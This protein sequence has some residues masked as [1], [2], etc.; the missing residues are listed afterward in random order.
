MVDRFGMQNGSRLQSLYRACK[1]YLRGSFTQL[2][3]E[4][5]DV[6]YIDTRLS[7]S[8]L[9]HAK[10]GVGMS[11]SQSTCW[12]GERDVEDAVRLRLLEGLLKGLDE[13]VHII[14]ANGMTVYYNRKMADIEGMRPED[15]IGKRIEDVFTFPDAAGSTLL[16]AVRLRL[17]RENVKQTYFN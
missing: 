11:S 5:I 8:T 16:Q 4:W 12:I 10:A 7:T 1:L 9:L 6:L 13:G 14:D 3:Y 15:V 17:A 2:S